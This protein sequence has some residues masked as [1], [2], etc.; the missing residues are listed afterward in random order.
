LR[1]Y[2]PQANGNQQ[3]ARRATRRARSFA[4][5]R[6]TPFL[7]PEIILAL[8]L[9]LRIVARCDDFASR[10]SF[11][12]TAGNAWVVGV[13]PRQGF[14]VQM[15]AVSLSLRPGGTALNDCHEQKHPGFAQGAR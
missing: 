9:V 12:A 7:Q 14:R 4:S 5:L 6:M 10:M 1:T 3:I 13:G 2:A 15:D 11:C 8:R